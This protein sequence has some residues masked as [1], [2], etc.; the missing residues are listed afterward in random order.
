[1][2]KARPIRSA[3]LRLGLHATRQR[4]VAELARSGI[5][6]GADRV[7]RAR[8]DL[9]KD[10]ARIRGPTVRWPRLNQRRIVPGKGFGTRR[11]DLSALCAAREGRPERPANPS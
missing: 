11:G 10:T 1:M 4:I 6:V 7:E 2:S 8:I 9:L 5:E 3:P